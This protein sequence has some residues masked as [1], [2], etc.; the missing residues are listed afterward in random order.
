MAERK[1]GRVT[2]WKGL[3]QILA[4]FRLMPQEGSNFPDY[5]AGQYIALRRDDCKLT[6]KV[7]VDGTSKII[8]DVD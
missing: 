5:K 7:N 4:I 6:K 1:I 8:P 2:Y 3:S